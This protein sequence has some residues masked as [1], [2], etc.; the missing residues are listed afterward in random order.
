MNKSTL[1]LHASLHGYLWPK[2]SGEPTNQVFENL[3]LAF[4]TSYFFASQIHMK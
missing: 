1:A 4:L 2:M 3:K